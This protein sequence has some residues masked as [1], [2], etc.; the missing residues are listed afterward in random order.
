MLFSE[1]K[2]RSPFI[3]GCIPAKLPEEGLRPLVPRV[4]EARTRRLSRSG[5]RSAAVDERSQP[6]E[7]DEAHEVREK[8]LLREASDGRATREAD[9]VGRPGHG[10]WDP[11]DGSNWRWTWLGVSAGAAGELAAAGTSTERPGLGG[12]ECDL[13]A[14]SVRSPCDLRAGRA[15]MAHVCMGMPCL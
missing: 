11:S 2:V 8:P 1:P 10:P 4:S 3:P 5:V 13:R 15:S 12:I 9:P 6:G 7:A 14:I